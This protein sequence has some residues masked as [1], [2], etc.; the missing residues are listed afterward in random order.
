MPRLISDVDD[1]E[2]T[3][4]F[5]LPFLFTTNT[6]IKEK[7]WVQRKIRPR[8]STF[9]GDGPLEEAHHQTLMSAPLEVGA[10]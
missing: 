9:D 4:C 8:H 7:I 1:L 10:G 6:K 2:Q 5:I 3:T